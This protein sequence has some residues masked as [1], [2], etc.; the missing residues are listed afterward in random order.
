MDDSSA[1][2]VFPTKADLNEIHLQYV[3]AF[4]V[5]V[6]LVGLAML[7]VCFGLGYIFCSRKNSFN[8]SKR[9]HYIGAGDSK[10]LSC[11]QVKLREFAGSKQ[12]THTAATN[13]SHGPTEESNEQQSMPSPPKYK[14]PMHLLEEGDEERVES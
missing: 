4:I 7:L 8:P 13:G 5:I 14:Y 3:A 2:P 12:N 6:I 9:Q 1:S 11:G 10:E